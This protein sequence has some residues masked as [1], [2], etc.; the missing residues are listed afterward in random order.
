MIQLLA[1]IHT[2][3]NIEM[4]S[5]FRSETMSLCQLFLQV[6]SSYESI[7]SLGELGLVQFRDLNPDVNAFQRKFIGEVKRCDEMERRVRLVEKEINRE[8]IP[9]MTI[10][11][12][13]TPVPP[14]KEMVI[15]ESKLERRENELKEVIKS[16]EAL[17]HTWQELN[18]LKH[19][20]LK[21]QGFFAET[22]AAVVTHAPAVSGHSSIGQTQMT[23]SI[24]DDTLLAN[25]AVSYAGARQSATLDSVFTD[26]PSTPTKKSPASK[27]MSSSSIS[28]VGIPITSGSFKIGELHLSF[29]TGVIA[30]EKFA[31]FER[32]LWRVCRGN[33]YLKSSEIEEPVQAN[34]SHS[35]SSSPVFKIAFIIFFQGDQLKSKVR[36]ICEG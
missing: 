11:Y 5:L 3:Q 9:I 28:S 34:F 32:M 15:L 2:N 10:D 22:E 13:N 19:V 18:E 8:S 27:K 23:G 12:F 29:L 7:K 25:F 20:L 26:G 24:T 31:T 4:G 16:S 14:A 17:N 21:S 1:P 35:K 30:R 33:V 6:E 36:K